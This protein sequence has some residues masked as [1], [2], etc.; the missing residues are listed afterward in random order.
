MDNGGDQGLQAVGAA[1]VLLHGVKSGELPD[2]GADGAEFAGLDHEVVGPI[3]GGQVGDG[4]VDVA[5]QHQNPGAV[6]RGKLP[7][8][9][10]HFDPV[11]A[12]EHHLHDH[13]V[14]LEGSD[15]LQQL[16][17]VVLL[18]SSWNDMTGPPDTS[19]AAK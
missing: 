3:G 17:A 18:F 2:A 6:L 4:P 7:Q 11:H 12:G 15:H 16:L 8:L 19:G 5:G 10:Q 9:L 14:G 13:G 1:L